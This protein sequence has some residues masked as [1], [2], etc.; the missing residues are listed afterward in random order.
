LEAVRE[1]LVVQGR[2]FDNRIYNSSHKFKTKTQAESPQDTAQREYRRTRGGSLAASKSRDKL[3]VYLETKQQQ[4][5]TKERRKAKEIDLHWALKKFDT[6]TR[7]S[8]KLTS[9][10]R[11]RMNADIEERMQGRTRQRKHPDTQLYV[12]QFSRSPSPP[13][14]ED[15]F[16]TQLTASARRSSSA[17]LECLASSAN[18]VSKL[19]SLKHYCD[20][21]RLDSQKSNCLLSSEDLQ[22]KNK[23]KLVQNWLKPRNSQVDPEYMQEHI[24]IFRKERGQILVVNDRKVLRL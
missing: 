2:N 11:R 5:A 16:T 6:T 23:F 15:I 8:R 9:A 19:E 21:V 17:S 7:Y 1:K 13:R 12:L 10:Q 22:L 24:D 4:Q 14:R 18:T 3:E 20:S